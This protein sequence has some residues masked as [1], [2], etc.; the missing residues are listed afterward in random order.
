[1][2]VPGDAWTALERALVPTAVALAAEQ[3]GVA[4]RSLEMAVEYSKVREQFGRKIGSFQAIKHKCAE[5]LMGVETAESVVIG[6]AAA[7]DDADPEAPAIAHLA[8][9]HCSE[10]AV[11]TATENIEV[12]GGIGFTWEH[13]A[14]LYYKRAVASS[15]LLGTPMAQRELMMREMGR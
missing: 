8:I 4:R 1:V 12:H 6:A 11:H 14:Q 15:A 2:G 3:A 5:M 7:V 10:V 9:A 13:P